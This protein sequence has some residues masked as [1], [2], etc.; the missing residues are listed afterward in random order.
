MTSGERKQSKNRISFIQLNKISYKTPFQ[1]NVI[2]TAQTNKQKSH[3]TTKFHYIFFQRHKHRQITYCIT[4]I[5]APTKQKTKHKNTLIDKKTDLA[6]LNLRIVFVLNLT[7]KHIKLFIQISNF[8]S[9]CKWNSFLS[10][11]YTF[12][13]TT[14]ITAIASR[15]QKMLKFFCGLPKHKLKCNT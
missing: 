12:G 2:H 10:K 8:Q 4:S 15:N 13:L 5:Y 9:L 1:I 3:I 7:Q 11:S 14:I 6:P